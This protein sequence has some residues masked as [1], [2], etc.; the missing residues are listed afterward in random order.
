FNVGQ[1]CASEKIPLKINLF[2]LSLLNQGWELST[3]I[4]RLLKIV[5]FFYFGLKT[6]DEKNNM[7]WINL[8]N[9]LKDEVNFKAP[10]RLFLIVKYFINPQ[11]IIQPTTEDIFFYCLLIKIQ[12]GAI[13]LNLEKREIILKMAS[14]YVFIELKSFHIIPQ[15]PEDEIFKMFHK[16]SNNIIW[17][18]AMI[19]DC[20][21]MFT[22]LPYETTLT[23][24][25]ILFLRYGSELYFYGSENFTICYYISQNQ[26]SVYRYGKFILYVCTDRLSVR[27]Y[28]RSINL[29]PSSLLLEIMYSDIST[30]T[31]KSLCVSIF[32]KIEQNNHKQKTLFKFANL[33]D[34]LAMFKIFTEFHTFFYCRSVKNIIYRREWPF[35]K[36]LSLKSRLFK[37][38]W[39]FTTGKK[40]RRYM[41]DVYCTRR[42]AYEYTYKFLND[43]H[44]YKKEKS[45]TKLSTSYIHEKYQ[46]KWIP[47]GLVPEGIYKQQSP[48]LFTHSPEVVEPHELCSYDPNVQIICSKIKEKC[49]DDILNEQEDTLSITY[50]I[51]QETHKN[52]NRRSIL[53]RKHVTLEELEE[54]II[55]KKI[56]LKRNLKS[57]VNNDIEKDGIVIEMNHYESNKGQCIICVDKDISCAFCPCGHAVTCLNCSERC[58][59]CPV[60]RAGIHLV[61]RIYFAS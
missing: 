61:Q 59:K 2:R 27:F 9:R 37:F 22:K 36:E 7:K 39:N 41:F 6:T 10:L 31:F 58:R 1:T 45:R 18:E 53:R 40:A 51:N 43:P 12:S 26:E 56:L 29:I 50:E 35:K 4:C 11:A 30:V 5:E 44:L 16:F 52:E 13:N 21:E 55:R 23:D 38:S 17:D 19:L 25:K 33:A 24:A 20:F 3:A 32:H 15:Y 60:C 49:L 54:D 42:Q 34:T 48:V 46:I 28:D 14:L 8:R 47:L 57:D